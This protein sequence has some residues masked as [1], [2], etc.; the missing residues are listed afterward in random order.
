[1][2]EF[3][4]FVEWA[5]GQAKAADLLGVTVGA[6]SHIQ[7]GRNGVSKRIASKIVE[8]AGKR[9]SVSKLLLGTA[10]A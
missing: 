6:I 4:R 8:V 5:G 3:N 7:T 1:M 2:D 10:A 9:F